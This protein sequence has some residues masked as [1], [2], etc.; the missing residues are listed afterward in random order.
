LEARAAVALQRDAER[1][2]GVTQEAPR[3]ARR[4]PGTRDD[5]RQPHMP[6]GSPQGASGGRRRHPPDLLDEP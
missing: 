3:G 1:T 6:A 4:Q 2:T 5:Q